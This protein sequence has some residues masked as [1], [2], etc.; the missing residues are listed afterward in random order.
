LTGGRNIAPTRSYERPACPLCAVTKRCI[1]WLTALR[2][3]IINPISLAHRGASPETIPQAEQGGGVP[4]AAARNRAAGVRAP[5]GQ[6]PWQDE[7]RAAPTDAKALAGLPAE[8]SAKAGSRIETSATVGAPRG[9]RPWAQGSTGAS[10]APPMRRD[11]HGVLPR[12]RLLALHPPL[13]GVETRAK[14]GRNAPR[15]RIR[16]LR[17]QRAV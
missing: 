17:K 7:K 11:T 13:E 16:L 3:C 6:A 4:A 15:E 12:V 14:L 9:G 8:A 5:A 10:Q 1:L 2:I